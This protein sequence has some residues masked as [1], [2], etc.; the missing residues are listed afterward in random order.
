MMRRLY[1]RTCLVVCLIAT[2]TVIPRVSAYA[3]DPLKGLSTTLKRSGAGKT[4]VPKKRS[5]SKA[6]TNAERRELIRDQKNDAATSLRNTRKRL[7]L[8]EAVRDGNVAISD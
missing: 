4:V 6:L 2:A 1:F 5:T 8:E 7:L 3:Y